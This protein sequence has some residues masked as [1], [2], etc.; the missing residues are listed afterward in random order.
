MIF[1][2]TFMAAAFG[3]MFAALSPAQ[4][5]VQTYAISGTLDSGFYIG[6][7]FSGSFSFDDAALNGLGDEWLGV[8]SLN[9]D[10]LGSSYALADADAP[11]EVGFYDGA[12]LGLS[13]SVSSSDPQLALIAGT[14]DASDA[15]FAYDTAAGISGAGSV[16]YAPV[17]EPRDWMLMLAGIGLVGMM[18]G[19]AKNRPF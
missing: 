19:R 1:K 16:I 9:L 17:P 8:S 13:Y 10:F 14:F 12:F 7:S 6:E 2:Q 18:V 4:A 3:L 5:A 15:F 11:A